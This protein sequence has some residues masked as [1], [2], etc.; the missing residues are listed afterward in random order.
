M[1]FL[2]RLSLIQK[3]NILPLNYQYELSSSLYHIFNNGNTDFA[4]WLHTTG[5]NKN[6][7]PFRLFTFS[8]L[9]I[10]DYKIFDDRI[11]I[12][13]DEVKLIVSLYPFEIVEPFVTGLFIN[14]T[15]DL[16]DK[17]SKVKFMINN[18]EKLPDIE[19]SSEM[20]FNCLSPIHIAWHNPRTNRI[21]FLHPDHRLYKELFFKNL[22]NKFNT[23]QYYRNLPE[24]NFDIS[25][26]KLDIL[27]EPRKKGI[28]IKVN[29]KEQTH[30]IGYSYKFKIFCQKELIRIGYY[31]GFGKANAQGFGCC[32]I[33]E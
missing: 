20:N 24:E 12:F 11:K 10:T 4:K 25:S 14:N 7:K 18:I 15:I 13:S 26:Y 9:L 6:N 16:G 17:K 8:N 32:G 29:T 1:R 19:F 2:L 28:N 3:E 21:D 5:F 31:A 23:Y 22:V 33:I 30:I 27:S